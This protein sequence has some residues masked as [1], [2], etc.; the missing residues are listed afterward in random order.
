MIVEGADA[1]AMVVPPAEV[2]P[3]QKSYHVEPAGRYTDLDVAFAVWT[4]QT[5]SAGPNMYWSG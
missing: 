1:F 2:V 3:V 5:R 4:G